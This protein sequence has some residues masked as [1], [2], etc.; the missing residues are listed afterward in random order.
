MLCSSTLTCDSPDAI[1]E[2]RVCLERHTDGIQIREAR[3]SA[4]DTIDGKSEGTT[5]EDTIEAKGKRT[6]PEDSEKSYHEADSVFNEG[7]QL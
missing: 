6:T 2:R 5:S 3:Q 7:S 4:A 1:Q